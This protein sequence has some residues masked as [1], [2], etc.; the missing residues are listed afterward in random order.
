MTIKYIYYVSSLN[1]Q[2]FFSVIVHCASVSVRHLNFFA[3]FM[4][5]LIETLLLKQP[6][7]GD[8]LLEY[9]ICTMEIC[10][11]SYYMQHTKKSW[12]NKRVHTHTTPFSFLSYSSLPIFNYLVPSSTYLLLFHLLYPCDWFSFSFFSNKN[13]AGYAIRCFFFLFFCE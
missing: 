2:F 8:E 7:N 4:Y 6:K 13:T 9:I 5:L 12:L 11:S 10:Y 1:M 3:I